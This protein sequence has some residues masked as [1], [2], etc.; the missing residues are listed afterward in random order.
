ME[1]QLF[2]EDIRKIGHT[3]FTE[4]GK[5]SV[6]MDGDNTFP[7]NIILLRNILLLFGPSYIITD[8]QEYSPEEQ[9]LEESDMLVRT[10]LPWELVVNLTDKY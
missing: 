8:V 1:L 9:C 6:I 7:L 3:L 10:N 2:K 4:D 5:L